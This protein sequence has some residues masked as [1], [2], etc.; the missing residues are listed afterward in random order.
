MKSHI[1]A[2]CM[3]LVGKGHMARSWTVC[4]EKGSNPSEC[5][6]F[7]SLLELWDVGLHVIFELT[8]TP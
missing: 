3:S 7:G 1:A 5:P 2:L 8:G 4:L 6:G